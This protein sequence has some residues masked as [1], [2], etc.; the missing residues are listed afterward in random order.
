M[1]I[2]SHVKLL[3]I[4][5]VTAPSRIVEQWAEILKANAQRINEKRLQR[6]PDLA[7]FVDR[8]AAL[9]SS[10]YAGV[11]DP[12]LVT[13]SGLK[14]RDI[15]SRQYAK[16]REAY[17]NYRQ[18]L[19]DTF[20][21]KDGVT[22]KEFKRLVDR[23]KDLFAKGVSRWTLPQTGTRAEELG[24]APIAAGWLIND[25]KVIQRLR[26]D[27]K[28]LEGGPFLITT[29]EKAPTLKT[30]LT[31]RL[32]QSGVVI[33][34]STFDPATMTD[35]N[36]LT[37]SIVQGFVNPALGIDPF[38]TGGTSHVD[39]IRESNKLFLDVQVSRV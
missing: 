15:V 30:A 39:F 9:S 14:R 16:L 20:A 32:T 23:A 26:A 33:M 6:I 11:I 28:I 25:R 13:R 8:L 5:P 3:V 10:G 36:T 19:E 35:H 31:Q 1:P 37:N 24:P 22:A 38:V 21:T 4:E 29:A 27:D 12:T 7:A 18:K 17:A 34:Q 2:V